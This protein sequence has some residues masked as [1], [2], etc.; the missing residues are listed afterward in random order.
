MK[1]N[2]LFVRGQ[3]IMQNLPGVFM[4]YNHFPR[5]FI[6]KGYKPEAGYIYEKTELIHK[7]VLGIISKPR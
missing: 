7:N 2:P 4:S 1:P 3:F 6:E 5:F